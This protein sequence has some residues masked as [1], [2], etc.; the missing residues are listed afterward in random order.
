MTTV[1]AQPRLLDRRRI[2]QELGVTL[3]SAETL[4]RRDSR[5]PNRHAELRIPSRCEGWSGMPD[6]RVRAT[7]VLPGRTHA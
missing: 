5:G 1:A 3:A 4:M 7:P 2:A 6:W